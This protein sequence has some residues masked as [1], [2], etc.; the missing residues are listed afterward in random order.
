MKDLDAVHIDFTAV[1]DRA[2]PTVDAC[3][4]ILGKLSTQDYIWIN[5]AVRKLMAYEILARRS[6]GLKAG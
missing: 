1:H 3:Q 4:R 6:T 5:Q 2:K